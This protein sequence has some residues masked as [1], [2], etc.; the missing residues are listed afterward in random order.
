VTNPPADLVIADLHKSFGEHPV[1]RGV[2]LVVPAGTFAA[3][4]G[5]SGSGKT[6][7]LRILAGFER[8]DRGS[9]AIGGIPLDDDQTHVRA[10]QRRIGYV[11]QEG[12]LFPHLSVE[13]NIG[14]GLSRRERR[15]DRVRDLL[16]MVGL[17]GLGGRYP[18]QLSGGQQ[19]RVALARA[20][21]VQPRLILLDEPFAALDATLRAS[22]R[23]DVQEILTRAGT[24][25][26]LVTHDQDEALSV[27]DLVAVM[28]DGQIA[29]VDEPQRLY[30]LPV[31]VDLG[32]F[33]GEANVMTGIARDDRVETPLG[34]LEVRGGLSARS[35]EAMTVL[36]RPEQVWV[37][38]YE[39]GPGVAGTV[40][41]TGFHGH[42][43]IIGIDIGSV[44]LGAPITSRV[45]GALALAPGAPVRINIRGPVNAWPTDGDPSTTGRNASL[46][47]VQA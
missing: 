10:E 23:E 8:P 15:G 36:V 16:D 38:P 42:D 41:H 11:P 14:F 39:D 37:F 6:T 2:N 32:G 4:V 18:H 29:Q 27:A 46:G 33:I 19:Q 22:V 12:S 9:V 30:A 43:S 35:G 40:V 24:T 34:M 47:D 13:A 17:E 25:A 21:A 3:I 45:L 5:Q 28:R 26:I 1:L 7:L 20:L 31:D 44:G